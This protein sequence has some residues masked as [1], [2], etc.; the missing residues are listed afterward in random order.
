MI[1]L[2]A[3]SSFVIN[4]LTLTVEKDSTIILEHHKDKKN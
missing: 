3:L 1:I 4:Q 2:N